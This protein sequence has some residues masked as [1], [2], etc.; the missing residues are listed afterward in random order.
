[1]ETI[2]QQ[3]GIKMA[4]EIV[5]TA[6]RC[7]LNLEKAIPRIMESLYGH[8]VGILQQLIEA[9]DKSMLAD[10]AGRRKE[11]WVVER[12]GD[13]RAVMTKIGELQYER[14]YY[15]NKRT[16]TYGYPIDQIIGVASY[17]RVGT[18]LSK[19]L[20]SESRQQ[21][22]HRTA[23]SCCSGRL[24][25]QTVL[26]K[27]RRA[28]AV[29]EKPPGTVS[30]PELHIDADEDHVAMQ[31]SR[32]RSR[33]TVPLVSVYEGIEGEG[34]RNHCRGIFHISAYGKSPDTLWEE[35]VT[36]IEQR[37]DLAN[38][39]IYLHGD[40]AGWIARGMEWLPNASFVLDKYHK[41]KYVHQLLA[42]YDAGRMRQLRRDLDQALYD[43]DEEYFENIVQMLLYE[44]PQRAEEIT[45]AANYLRSHMP[46]IAIQRTDPSAGNG[47]ATEPHVSHV[48]SSRLSS[49]P[50]GWSK[51]TLQ[52][53]VPI[54]ANGPEVTFEHGEQTPCTSVAAVK[55]FQTTRRR[56]LAAQTLA[57]QP[58]SLPII[59]F[60]KRTELYKLLRNMEYSPTN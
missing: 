45:E 19:E 47:G 27:I 18:G 46:A 23:E 28:E 26:N 13:R 3:T 44:M 1:M 39:R 37:Y 55:A 8:T 40:G 50:M 51:K 58:S 9:T 30:V 34:T 36:R 6:L 42:G 15:E 43:M 29:I 22:Y 33:T 32:Y 20:V 41:N 4:G 24:S 11:G 31:D 21:S 57:K 52:R 53:F 10:K 35:V 25:R 14:A 17:Q 16:G 38:T 60:G 7:H 2:I 12:H 56:V 5:E 59:H 48:L 49:R 54:L